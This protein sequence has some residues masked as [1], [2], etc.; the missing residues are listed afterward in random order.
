MSVI[1]NIAEALKQ[2]L[3]TGT[4]GQPFTPERMYVPEF[5]LPEMQTMRVSVVPAAWNMSLASRRQSQDEYDIF[6]GIQ[7]KLAGITS[8]DVDPMLALVEEIA[9]FLKFRRLASYPDPVW[10]RTENEPI[11]DP[12]HLFEMNQFTSILT[13]T[14]RL[15]H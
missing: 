10:V 11:Y 4:F 2:E 1:Q 9:G 14:Y 15:L 8:A 12:D 5:T 6:V 13:V 7:K 3:T